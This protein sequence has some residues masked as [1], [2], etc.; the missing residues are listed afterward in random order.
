[1]R[2]QTKPLHA[3]GRAEPRFRPV[4]P[5]RTPRMRRARPHPRE[6][7]SLRGR[8]QPNK[9][10]DTRY[11]KRVRLGLLGPAGDDLA[12]LARATEFLL[13]AAK[14]TRAIYLGDSGELEEMVS[15]WAESLVGPDTS[16]AG[17]WERSLGAALNG[18]PDQ[19]DALV[20]GER[21]RLRLKSVEGLATLE[22][23]SVE[24]FGDRVAVLVHDKAL[25]D[26]EDILSA[27]FLI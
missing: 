3:R 16:D 12:A 1:M 11:G 9:S 22:L 18:T 21:A 27:T 8:P 23:R 17:V 10:R 15:L 26:E 4:R 19:I 13:N 24:M 20:R 2:P 14:V 25:L 5:R 6:V 7:A